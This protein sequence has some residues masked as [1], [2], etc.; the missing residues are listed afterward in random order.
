MWHRIAEST[1]ALEKYHF[2]HEGNR[3]NIGVFLYFIFQFL[4]VPPADKRNIRIL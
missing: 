1:R 3:E 2:E 4:S